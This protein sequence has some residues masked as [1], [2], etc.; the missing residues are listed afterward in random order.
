M[1]YQGLYKLHT[2]RIEQKAF[3]T[4]V[5]LF[6][7]PSFTSEVKS[8]KLDGTLRLLTFRRCVSEVFLW[9]LLFG[10]SLSDKSSCPPC[11]LFHETPTTVAEMFFLRVF[12]VFVVFSIV[13]TDIDSE[14]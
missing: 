11:N 4:K 12:N 7:V 13:H 9:G 3:L 6:N 10:V 8:V 2:C 14:T 1:V 5:T